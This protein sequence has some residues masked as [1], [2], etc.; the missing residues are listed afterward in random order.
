MPLPR[1]QLD[2][3]GNRLRDSPPIEDADRHI[4]EEY[5]AEHHADLDAIQS[6]VADASG[7]DPG[8]RLKTLE[9]TIAKLQRQRSTRLSQ[10]SDIA[11][12]R[13][14]VPDLDEQD[15]VVSEL[16]ARLPSASVRDMRENPH[17]GYRAVHLFVKGPGGHDVEIQVRTAVQNAWANLSEALAARLDPAVKYGGGPEIVRQTLLEES[18]EAAQIDAYLREVARLE[19]AAEQ[20][21]AAE[22]TDDERAE[23]MRENVRQAR[24]AAQGLAQDFI[25]DVASLISS[26]GQ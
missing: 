19:R 1:S 20:R 3:A 26:I 21:L 4:Y 12:C 11:G 10:I 5:R 14:T 23:S 13:I 24:N 2:R 15:R 8:S 6:I 16:S 7:L 25:D 17:H 18:V 22:A 9:S